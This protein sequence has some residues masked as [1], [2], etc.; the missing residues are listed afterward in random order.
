MTF[1]EI[2]QGLGALIPFL[3]AGIMFLIRRRVFEGFRS[4]VVIITERDGALVQVAQLQTKLADVERS[5]ADW[6]SSAEALQARLKAVIGEE[7]D[8][9]RPPG[10][11]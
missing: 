9:D 11:Q 2:L 7:S 5:R 4:K 3:G 1:P 6:R 8:D 10:K